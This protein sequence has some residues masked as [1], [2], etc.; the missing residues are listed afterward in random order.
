MCILSITATN[1]IKGCKLTHLA[2]LFKASKLVWQRPWCNRFLVSFGSNE[3]MQSNEGWGHTYNVTLCWEAF[4]IWQLVGTLPRKSILICTIPGWFM[5]KVFPLI[6]YSG[7]F[8]NT[9]RSW[10]NS[11]MG[12]TCRHNVMQKGFCF[13][14]NPNFLFFLVVTIVSM[15]L[16]SN[17]VKVMFD[18]V[19]FI[20]NIWMR[21]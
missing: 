3:I 5:V 12:K 20:A 2:L 14:L 1:E 11:Q 15:T 13:S 17:A 16:M 19:C 18:V 8:K 7:A 9:H 6:F 4:F 21:D 10:V